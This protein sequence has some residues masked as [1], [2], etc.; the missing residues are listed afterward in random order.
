MKF[1]NLL[2]VGAFLVS[3][4][5]FAE[6][7]WEDDIRTTTF[8]V[9]NFNAYGP[10]YAPDVA[11]RT[12]KMT[13]FL[14][15]QSPCDVVHL[16]EVWNKGHIEQVETALNSFYQ[17]SAPNKEE[18]IGVMSMFRGTIL[19]KQ[20][21]AFNVNNEGGMLDNVREAFDVKKAY[22]VVQS[23]LNDVEEKIFFMNTH[24]HPSSQAVRLTQILD[25]LQWRLKNQ[26]EKMVLSG[27][28]NA[29]IDSLERKVL[30][31]SLGVRD[32]MEESFGGKYPAGYCTYC[33]LNNL[34]LMFTNHTFDYI[35]YS[36]VGQAD[37]QLRPFD[38][39][40]NMK[41]KTTFGIA[42]GWSDHFGVRVKFAVQPKTANDINIEVRREEALKA[43]A[44]ADAILKVQERAEFKPYSTLVQQ[45]AA[46]LKDRN[47]TFN[48]YF[49]SY[50]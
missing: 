31:L 24:L 28:F 15:S 12:V 43:L 33:F 17:V 40:V 16:Q 25:L 41:G 11:G 14:K 19:G 1:L 26:S 37:T 5:A 30:M 48:S 29:D 9:Q 8:C 42:E 46:E 10:I 6:T 18:T 2:A 44:D 22:H 49:E 4:N 39:E 21:V 36:N 20:T 27:D 50:R 47:G 45:L 35:F 3:A 38:G 23:N 13:K 32:S 34:S 7:S